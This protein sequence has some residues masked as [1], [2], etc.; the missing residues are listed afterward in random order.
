MYGFSKGNHKTL[1]EAA[2]E[3]VQRIYE[4]GLSFRGGRLSPGHNNV[5]ADA[6]AKA[7]T[8][9]D[10]QQLGRSPSALERAYAQMI[11]LRQNYAQL[12][13][14]DDPQEAGLLQDMYDVAEYMQRHGWKPRSEMVRLG[15]TAFAPAAASQPAYNVDDFR[16]GPSQ[17]SG[18]WTNLPDAAKRILPSKTP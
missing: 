13:Q 7:F 6:A 11:Q 15:T 10:L 5:R 1:P 3:A 2:A 9:Q 17:W 4:S 12:T 18:D 8:Q 16:A 14:V